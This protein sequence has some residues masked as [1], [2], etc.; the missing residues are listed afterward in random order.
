MFYCLFATQVIELCTCSFCKFLSS[1][2]FHIFLNSGQNK[3]KNFQETYSYRY[4]SFFLFMIGKCHCKS[5]CPFFRLSKMMLIASMRRYLLKQLGRK[6]AYADL[7][8][9]IIFERPSCFVLFKETWRNFEIWEVPL[10][11]FVLSPTPSC[12][13]CRTRKIENQIKPSFSP[14]TYTK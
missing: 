6:H 11:K 10:E 7:A 12:S 8:I 5:W 14:T 1:S 4:V 13:S 3:P 9:I 2:S